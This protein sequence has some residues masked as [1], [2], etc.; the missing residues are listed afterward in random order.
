MQVSDIK[1][2][3]FMLTIEAISINYIAEKELKFQLY[4]HETNT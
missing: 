3:Q 1:P 2:N 4:S